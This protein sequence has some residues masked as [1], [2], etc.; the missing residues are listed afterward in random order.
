MKRVFFSSRR[1]A[2]GRLI[3]A[4]AVLG[5]VMLLGATSYYALG[6]GRWSWF[7]CFYMTI[8]TLSTVGFAETLQGMNEVPEARAV[9][10]ALIVLGSGTLLYF[11]SSLTALIVEGDLQ[12]ILRRRSMQRAIGTLNDHVIVCG[13]GTTGRHIATELSAVGIPFVVVDMDRLRLEE[14]NEEFE[15]GL[16]YVLG[17]ATDDH[18]LE[19][20][21]VERAR[22]VI[23]ALND[24]KANLFVTI[25]AR[26]LNPNAR[27]VSKA[28]ESSTEAKLRRAGADAV[29]APNYIGGVRLFSEMVSPKTVAFLDRMVRFGSGISVGIEAI[30][31]PEGSPLVGK[32]IAETDLREAGAL[33]V[34]VHC[35]DGEYVYAPGSEHLLQEGDSLIVLAESRDVKKLRTNVVAGVGA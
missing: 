21:G 19:L 30:D 32:R 26:A 3:S 18:T 25:T 6:Q 28:I 11:I 16:L 27:I 24:D 2:Y 34:A 4:A 35:S 33:V 29:V 10:I 1:S 5:A 31:I 15:G 9:T 13:I 12:G 17:D 23:S 14:L 8:I 22:G 7:D 20:A